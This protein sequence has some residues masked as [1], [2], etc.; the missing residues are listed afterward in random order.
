MGGGASFDIDIRLAPLV[1]L[2]WLRPEGV[3]QP[4]YQPLW[5]GGA[6]GPGDAAAAPHSPRYGGELLL[7]QLIVVAAGAVQHHSVLHHSVLQ[8]V[9]HLAGFAPPVQVY[10]CTLVYL[11]AC[12]PVRLYT[13]TW[14]TSTTVRAYTCRGASSHFDVMS[15]SH[16]SPQ[17]IDE[18][19]D[20]F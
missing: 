2:V 5:F 4:L 19:I 7:R 6:A 8:Y 15:R 11:Y 14:Y 1:S 20:I 17:C 9:Q 13:Y 10:T 3:A 16:A 18:P 12:V